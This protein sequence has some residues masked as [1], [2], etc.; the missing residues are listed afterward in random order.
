MKV[1]FYGR[2][3][4]MIASELEVNS[5]AG[6]S[7]SQLRERL[8]A[9]YPLAEQTLQSKRARTCVGDRLVND[10]HVLSALDTVEFLPPVSGG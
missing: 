10:D 9:E 4:E 5:P 3:A 8:A 7:V 6:C 2:L 1:L